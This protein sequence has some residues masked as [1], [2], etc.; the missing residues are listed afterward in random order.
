MTGSTGGLNFSLASG[1]DGRN[2]ANSNICSLIG[3]GPGGGMGGAGSNAT[4]SNIKYKKS[5]SLI[6]K[7]VFQKII[8]FCLYIERK[9][10]YS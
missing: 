6:T 5:N 10:A 9:M 3:N 1:A 2:N 8:R 4:T 7:K